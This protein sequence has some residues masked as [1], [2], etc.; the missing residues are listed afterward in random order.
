L[1]L[2]FA[3]IVIEGIILAMVQKSRIQH[4]ISTCLIFLSLLLV[5]HHF[6]AYH[7]VHLL[8][9][10]TAFLLTYI[11]VREP[12]LLAEYPALAHYIVPVGLGLATSVGLLLVITVNKS[13]YREFTEYW[14]ASTVLIAASM[15]YLAQQLL[16]EYEAE[17]LAWAVFL[18][19]ALVLAPTV[20]A[21]GIAFSLLLLALGF[22]RGH[23]ILSALGVIALIGFTIMFYYNLQLSLLWKSLVLVASGLLLL[24]LRWGLMRMHA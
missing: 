3:G 15:V 11:W 7:G 18:A 20:F 1:T 8:I 17:G 9:G 10:G 4:F 16:A 13:W 22:Y 5:L 14:W 19:L 21:P 24:V 2:G 6:K 12:K 23:L